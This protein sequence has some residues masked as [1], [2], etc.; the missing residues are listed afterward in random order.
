VQER[1]VRALLLAQVPVLAQVR[2]LEQEL[3]FP[4]QVWLL[5]QGEVVFPPS[6]PL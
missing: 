5:E 3:R 2:L 1:L 6:L 4:A